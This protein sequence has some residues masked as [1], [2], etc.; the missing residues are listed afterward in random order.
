MNEADINTVVRNSLTWGFKIPDPQGMSALSATSRCFDGFGVHN[1]LPVYWESKFS[2]KL[3]SFNLQRL[4]PHQA[5]ALTDI[6]INLSPVCAWVIYGV[7]ADR[8][9]TRLYVF[10]WAY[11]QKRYEEKRN[12]LKKELERLPYNP[13]KKG[14][15]T[16]EFV[17]KE[18]I[19]SD[20]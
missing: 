5:K 11:L 15:A 18:D 7:H 1:N 13:V 14:L 19:N 12:V 9:D 6:I 4:E 17:I 20:V 10:D 16:F 2:Q 8:G 3:Q